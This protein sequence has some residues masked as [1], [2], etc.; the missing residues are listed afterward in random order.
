MF[1]NQVE[2][3]K[4]ERERERERESDLESSRKRKRVEL[5]WVYMCGREKT[6]K[7]KCTDEIERKN[8]IKNKKWQLRNASTIFSQ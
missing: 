8:N 4:R 3:E 6:R 1:Y 2:K 5:E 7:K